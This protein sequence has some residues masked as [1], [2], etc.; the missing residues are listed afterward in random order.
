[1]I[2]HVCNN[3]VSSKVHRKIVE[4]ISIL[5]SG[6]QS[7]FIPIRKKSDAWVNSFFS[8]DVS[9]KYSRY[10]GFI[11]YFPFIKVLYNFLKFRRFFKG[12]DDSLPAR[13]VLAHTLW[14]D[15]S[16]AYFAYKAFGLRYSVVI[17]NTDINI[18]IPK[19]PQYRW[20]VKKIISNADSV[21]FVNGVYQRRLSER[22]PE[23]YRCIRNSWLIYNG[24]DDFW[25]GS[26]FFGD[27]SSRDCVC[28]VG[29]FNHN[30]NLRNIYGSVKEARKSNPK[31]KLVL[32]GG[33]Q[34]EFLKVVQSDVIP[35]WVSVLG[36]VKEKEVIS[37]Y[38]RRSFV[39]SMP[40]FSETFGLVYL[41]ALSQGCNLICSR[42]EG[43]DG[44][45]FGDHI[46]LVDPNDVNEIADAVLNYYGRDFP[47]GNKKTISEFLD[48]FSWERVAHKYFDAIP[49]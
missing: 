11:K 8:G 25:L 49:K 2:V 22:F 47:S 46:T 20:F 39:F 23:L 36:K 6:H 44:V 21:I 4:K 12:L 29:A 38:L 43:V 15:G 31:I 3:Y 45:V 18:F 16:I 7:V 5:F 28:Y 34:A 41:E 26:K 19:L 30:K 33:T 48:E 37:S 9:F 1:M 13:S 32:I 40:S 42:G 27:F 17:R 14:T 24:L 10:P 35:N